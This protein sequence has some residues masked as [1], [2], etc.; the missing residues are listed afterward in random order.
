MHIVGVGT[1][2]HGRKIGY[3]GIVFVGRGG[4]GGHITVPRSF[5]IGLG[6]KIA[7]QQIVR[8]A[9]PAQQVQRHGGKLLGSTPLHEQHIIIVGDGHQAAQIFLRLGVD[10][11]IGTRTVAD[12]GDA[13]AGAVK[14]EQLLLCLPQHAFGQGRGAGRKIVNTHSCLLAKRCIHS[15]K[16][17]CSY[18]NTKCAQIQVKMR[19]FY[20]NMHF[21]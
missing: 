15:A 12:L 10:L 3:V 8:T 6:G 5:L 16:N 2:G 7:R 11:H 9:K 1:E 18:Y 21:Q 20:K 14:V 17:N 13:H 19:H 4:N